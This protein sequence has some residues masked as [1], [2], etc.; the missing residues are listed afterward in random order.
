MSSNLFDQIVDRTKDVV[1]TAASKTEEMVSKQKV[2]LDLSTATRQLEKQQAKL[3]ALVYGFHL[4]QEEDEVLLKEYIEDV[5]RALDKVDSIK[6][7]LETISKPAYCG[8]CGAKNKG[9]A[10]FCYKCGGN[11]E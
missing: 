2:K 11:L 1:T 7:Q 9:D 8:A 5:A 6:K 4:A 3:G 10:D